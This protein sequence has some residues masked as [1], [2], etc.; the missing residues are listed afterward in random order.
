T[1]DAQRVY[2]RE[3]MR[4][5]RRARG[6][7]ERAPRQLRL[8]LNKPL[9]LSEQERRKRQKARYQRLRVELIAYQRE[10]MKANPERVREHQVLAGRERFARKRASGATK[11]SYRLVL[12]RDGWWGG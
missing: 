12:K 5:W 10:W 4:R 3:W 8:R 6:A 9:R 1:A 7:L 2:S 11:V